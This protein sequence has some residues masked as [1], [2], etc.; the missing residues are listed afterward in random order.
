MARKRMPPF[1]TRITALGKGGVGVG[2]APD[3]RPVH[4]RFAPPGSVVRVL[5]QGKR[6]GVWQGRRMD[7]VE[8]PPDALEPRCP[9][10]ALCGGCALQELRQ[11]AQRNARERWTR[12]LL[13]E[14]PRQEVIHHILGAS[15]AWGYRNKIELS[16]GTRRYL[17]EAD[18]AAGLPIPGRY[19]G[20]HASGRFDRVV[21][22]EHCDLASPAMNALL[23]QI[24]ARVFG[25]DAPAP[26]D[27]KDHTG[28]WRHVTLR[29]GVATRDLLVSIGTTTG[30]E[31]PV[32]ALA[33]DLVGVKFTSGHRVVG[34]RWYV[35]DGLADVARGTERRVWGR[36][37]VEEYLDD[38]RYRLSAD[39][40]F[41]SS[42]RG[43][44]VLFRT[45]AKALGE[46]QGTLL[47]LYC[48]VGA[49][50]LVLAGHFDRVVGVEEVP[51]AV[52]DA[53]ENA[54]LN[55]LKHVEF[56]E[57][58]VEDLLE[59]VEAETPRAIVVDPPRVG[60]HPRVARALAAAR[61]EV[62]VYVACNPASLA[63]DAAVLEAGGWRLTDVWPVD[64]FPQTGH[65]EAVGRFVRDPAPT[66]AGAAPT[67]L[68]PGPA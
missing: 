56:H 13:A 42:T 3:G 14:L 62:L 16:F 20:F 8:P 26:Y 6:K 64:L 41:Q 50:G 63:R 23:A 46:G 7:L 51:E 61:A 2:E 24:R 66:A 68:E 40:F 45:V 12:Q 59:V 30:P 1:E 27:V 36:S 29:E 60:L 52:R 22:V 31:A 11:H 35:N 38:T 67:G 54:A 15:P 65:V 43:A 10:F 44:A 53:R 17:S 9:V 33:R 25:P 4:V 28:F 18:M 58:R 39:A 19:L 21:D 49:I 5:P 48:G 32:E 47:D 37:F 55:R 57:G 34:V